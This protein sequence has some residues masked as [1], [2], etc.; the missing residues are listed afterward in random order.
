MW[1]S[2]IVIAYLAK[3]YDQ[4]FGKENISQFG[5]KADNLNIP[6]FPHTSKDKALA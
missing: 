2:T 1:K 3:E 5:E 4:I 6:S